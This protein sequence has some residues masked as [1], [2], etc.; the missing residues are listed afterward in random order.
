MTDY[1]GKVLAEKYR[2]DLRIGKSGLGDL[3][4]GA[5]LAMEKPVT[6]K[7]L[8]PELAVDQTIA[9]QFA[10]EA[11]T[12]SRLQHPNILNVTDSGAD[13][14][15]SRYI[16]YENAGSNSLKE[17]IEREN[18]FPLAR[19]NKIVRQ[20]AA[21]LAVAH[22]ADIVHGKLTDESVILNETAAD[23]DAVKVVFDSIADEP[24]AGEDISVR[25]AQFL[26][27][28]QCTQ[29][30]RGSERSDV[31]SL[32]VILYEM[33]AGEVPF[34]AATANDV[35]LKQAQ[36]PPLSLSAFRGDLPR[37]VDSVVMT[38]LAKNP[39]SR[40][41]TANEFAA[42]LNRA[43]LDA[44]TLEDGRPRLSVPANVA[45]V[46]EEAPQNNLWKTAFILL[47]GVAVLSA[48]FIYITQVKQTNPPTQL[49]TDA[50]GI[51]VQPVNPATGA[52]EQSLA[53]MGGFSPQA[54]GNSNSMMNGSMPQVMPGGDGYD[55]WARGVTPPP[56][57]PQGNYTGP[58]YVA[59]PTG[60]YYDGNFNP[61]SPFMQDGNTYI[62]VP[63]NSNTNVN[64]ATRR[65]QANANAQAPANA[66]TK[67]TPTTPA[68]NT[69]TAP[70][71]KPTPAKPATKTTPKPDVSPKPNTTQRQTSG[72]KEVNT[73]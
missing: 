72:G 38:A 11:K 9:E 17:T 53:N 58:T 67:P 43:T 35:M 16:V 10:L 51:P 4:H 18:Q 47:A 56:G 2:I 49:A 7:I 26:S 14:T 27:P 59:P 34:V 37:E 70:D 32:G 12:L 57:A 6:I 54:F 30:S 42:A 50:N 52:S 5:H 23:T 1:S 44:A 29:T 28:E 55:P 73:F 65:N 3:Y 69:A 25:Q 20:V 64:T 41:A 13:M 39:E 40:F 62:L 15:G 63:K 68:A 8:P 45:A 19:A 48:F 60:Q 71:A 46:E 36:E 22:S 61:N 24:V 31:Y 21:A 66:V 33:L